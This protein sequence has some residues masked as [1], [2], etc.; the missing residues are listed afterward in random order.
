M[1]TVAAN[2]G[3]GN[4]SVVITYTPVAVPTVGGTAGL[5]LLVAGLLA[6]TFLMRRQ[7]RL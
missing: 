6:A 5:A 1:I 4:G 3:G 2:A 7:R